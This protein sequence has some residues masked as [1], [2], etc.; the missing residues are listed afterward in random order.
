MDL[1]NID[2]RRQNNEGARDA[3]QA[4]LRVGLGKN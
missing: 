2:Q 3:D 4:I 1:K